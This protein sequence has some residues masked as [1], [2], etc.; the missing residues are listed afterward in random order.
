MSEE[1]K[2]PRNNATAPIQIITMKESIIPRLREL[3]IETATVSYSGCG[4]EGAVEGIEIGPTGIKIA[5]TLKDEISDLTCEFLCAQRCG[6]GDNEGSTGTLVINVL[7]NTIV[8]EHG[9]Y[10]TDVEYDEMEF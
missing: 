10:I 2:E 8:N 3:G 6:W 5:E 4:D 7:K 1:K 9:W